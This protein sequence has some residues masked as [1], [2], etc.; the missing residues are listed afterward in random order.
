MATGAQRTERFFKCFRRIVEEM[1]GEPAGDEIERSVRER[2][3]FGVHPPKAHVGE[4]SAREVI[5][6][7]QKHLLGEIDPD[8]PAIRV[9]VRDQRGDDC[10]ATGGDVQNVSPGIGSHPGCKQIGEGGKERHDL[11]VLWRDLVEELSPIRGRVVLMRAHGA[12][13]RFQR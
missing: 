5:R 8:K 13:C 2:E 9:G 3:T 11:I 10:P 7:V 4:S 1:N 6:G 12:P